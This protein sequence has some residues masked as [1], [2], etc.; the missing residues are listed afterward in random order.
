MIFRTAVNSDA[1]FIADALKDILKLHFDGRHD[2][3][4]F[5]GAKYSVEEIEKM[6][7]TDGTYIFVAEDNGVLCG[8][9]ICY[10]RS[11]ANNYILRDRKIFYLDDLYILP[12]HRGEGT[13]KLF[14]DMLVSFAKNNGF[15]SFELNVWEFP[16]SATDFYKKCGFVTQKRTME[17]K[18]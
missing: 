6:I 2:I 7:I 8:Y 4:R 13:G 9:S 15:E 14:M 16:N 3:F 17:L 1:S 18:L 10:D 11:V 12:S 5:E